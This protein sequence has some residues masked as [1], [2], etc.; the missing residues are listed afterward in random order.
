MRDERVTTKKKTS[1]EAFNRDDD[2]EQ[3]IKNGEENQVFKKMINTI[4]KFTKNCILICRNVFSTD[5]L[6][7]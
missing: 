1:Q 6:V 3:Q 2:D 7:F 5:T 4:R